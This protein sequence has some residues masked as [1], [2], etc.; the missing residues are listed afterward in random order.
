M[1]DVLINQ[2][3]VIFESFKIKGQGVFILVFVVPFHRFRQSPSCHYHSSFI[4]LCFV[5]CRVIVYRIV[6]RYVIFCFYASKDIQ[7]SKFS[8]AKDNLVRWIRFPVFQL[9]SFQ[10]K[11]G[12]ECDINRLTVF[13]DSTVDFVYQSDNLFS[14]VKLLPEFFFF[15]LSSQK[16]VVLLQQR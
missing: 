5:V 8:V 16:T 10:S 11:V 6:C 1:V 3:Q 14:S 9:S 7:S 4:V 2:G 15:Y 13:S 12:D